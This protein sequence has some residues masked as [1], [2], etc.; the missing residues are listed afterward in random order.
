MKGSRSRINLTSSP[1]TAPPLTPH[2]IPP[3]GQY[4][5]SLSV[6][7]SLAQP[8]LGGTMR[9]SRGTLFVLP[10]GSSGDAAALAAGGAGAAPAAGRGGAGGAGAGAGAAAQA[11][12]RG[13]RWGD[14]PVARAF[15]AFT[16]TEPDLAEQIN[17]MM[18]QEVRRRL[19]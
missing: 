8:T 18:A 2:P 14:G 4:D 16:R 10:A 19:S 17:A 12:A 1:P 13:Q 9:F 3:A 6:T 11:P 5:A 7:S 15:E